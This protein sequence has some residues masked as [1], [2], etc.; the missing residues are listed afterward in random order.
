M[1][2]HTF[3]LP[4]PRF[5]SNNPPR[6]L[7]L[8]W[9]DPNRSISVL[10]RLRR[11]GW[12]PFVDHHG[13]LETPVLLFTVS[14]RSRVEPDIVRKRALYIEH[15]DPMGW[16]RRASV[17]CFN[18]WLLH[19]SPEDWDRDTLRRISLE[20]DSSLVITEKT[21]DLQLVTG[22]GLMLLQGY[23]AWEANEEEISRRMPAHFAQPQP[24]AARP[25]RSRAQAPSQR[26]ASVP[27]L[28]FLP[29]R[30]V[31]V[32]V[33]ETVFFFNGASTV[34]ATVIKKVQVR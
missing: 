13:T 19:E 16:G 20:L 30:T 2:E 5:E 29:S 22:E 24:R 1:E 15:E 21:Q 26:R 14:Y 28:I 34:G 18:S 6:S 23:A 31:L 4:V 33:S 9:F 7:I 12:L 32:F 25:L 8:W 17:S 10:E 27:H 3:E 11:F